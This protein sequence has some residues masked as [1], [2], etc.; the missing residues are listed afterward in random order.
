MEVE[1]FKT[2]LY[3]VLFKVVSSDFARVNIQGAIEVGVV[4]GCYMMV[5]QFFLGSGEDLRDRYCD[6]VLN[7]AHPSC[8]HGLDSVLQIS[9]LVVGSLLSSCFSVTMDKRAHVVRMVTPP[10]GD[11]S[12]TFSN[13]GVALD[14]PF[15]QLV[16]DTRVVIILSEMTGEPVRVGH[17]DISLLDLVI[18]HNDCLFAELSWNRR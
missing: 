18:P 14:V 1:M 8:W 12:Q 17:H 15:K 9:D 13:L 10:V 6:V 2:S 3:S 4:I 16:S 5:R 7:S 11:V